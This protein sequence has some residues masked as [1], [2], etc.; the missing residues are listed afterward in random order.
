MGGSP[1]G[2]MAWAKWRGM[3]RGFRGGCQ[4]WQRAH[5]HPKGTVSEAMMGTP[6]EERR[7]EK[8]RRH[9]MHR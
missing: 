5:Q 7:E 2:A 6:S 9:D 4:T 8:T 1:E 3:G